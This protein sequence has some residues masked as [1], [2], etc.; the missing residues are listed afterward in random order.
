M[1]LEVEVKSNAF[2]NSQTRFPAVKCVCQEAKRKMGLATI[3]AVTSAQCLLVVAFGTIVTRGP[4]RSQVHKGFVDP[5]GQNL[6]TRQVT[7][8]SVSE[9][10]FL[11]KTWQHTHTH[12]YTP[13]TSIRGHNKIGRLPS[14]RKQQS[15]CNFQ[16][17]E[18]AA[19]TSNDWG[20]GR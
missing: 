3:A 11:H 13:R 6:D 12:T 7:P 5:M 18:V 1:K 14:Q 8:A 20:I 4:W 17:A 2:V 19:T 10:C 9:D 15:C 16:F